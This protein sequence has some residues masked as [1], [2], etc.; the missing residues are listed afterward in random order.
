MVHAV[1]VIVARNGHD[2]P[3][4][5]PKKIVYISHSANYSP[6]NYD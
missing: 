1:M 5:N 3:I 4:L 2:D 6:S